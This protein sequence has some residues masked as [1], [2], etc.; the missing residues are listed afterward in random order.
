MQHKSKANETFGT[1][2]YN[3]CVKH[4]QHLDKTLA[5]LKIL[6]ATFKNETAETFG[7]YPCNMCETYATSR[8][9]HTFK[10]DETL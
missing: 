8:L 1:Y 5:V 4:M 6:T 7:T 2:T 10:T 9:Q 3:I